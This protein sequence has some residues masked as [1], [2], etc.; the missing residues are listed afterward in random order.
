MPILKF[1]VIPT[2]NTYEEYSEEIVSK[3]KEVNNCNAELDRNYNETL[4]AR[5][6]KYK[7]NNKNVITIGLSEVEHDTIMI[8]FNGAR[9]KTME[10]D[11]FIALLESYDDDDFLNKFYKKK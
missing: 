3:I 7:K 6:N 4:N 8:H 2:K 1:I 9:P 10:C 11:E 5:V